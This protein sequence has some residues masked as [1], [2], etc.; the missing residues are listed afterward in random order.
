MNQSAYKQT[1]CKSNP[2]RFLYFWSNQISRLIKLIPC[3]LHRYEGTR[4]VMYGTC[5]VQDTV[6]IAH[7]V[8]GRSGHVE[9]DE[10]CLLGLFRDDLIE[11]QRRMHAPHVRL[12]PDEMWHETETRIPVGVWFTKQ[13]SFGSS[14][15]VTHTY[16][17][18]HS[19]QHGWRK[20]YWDL[21][22]IQVNVSCIFAYV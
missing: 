4:D 1:E 21:F 3:S 7:A 16:R 18:S 15:S 13:K 10:L 5:T 22:R 12:V 9:Q 17:F 19:L 11:P 20:K 2:F 14:H 8:L 6:F